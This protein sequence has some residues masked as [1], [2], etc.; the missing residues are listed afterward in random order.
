MFRALMNER[1]GIPKFATSQYG[2]NSFCFWRYVWAK[3]GQCSHELFMRWIAGDEGI[4]MS[5]MRDMTLCECPQNSKPL[6]QQHR[7]EISGRP[8]GI[9][10]GKLWSP[11]NQALDP[12]QAFGDTCSAR[13]KEIGPARSCA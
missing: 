2:H 4:N 1:T 8:L 11:V 12:R 5:L 6:D 7:R 9:P 13:E 10:R 3:S